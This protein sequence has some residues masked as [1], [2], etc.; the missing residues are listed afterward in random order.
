VGVLRSFLDGF[1][2]I[3]NSDR[4]KWPIEGGFLVEIEEPYRRGRGLVFKGFRGQYQLGWGRPGSNPLPPLDVTPEEI[5]SW[6]PPPELPPYPLSPPAD[7]LLYELLYP[8]SKMVYH[9]SSDFGDPCWLPFLDTSGCTEDARRFLL[10]PAEAGTLD[11]EGS[12]GE[13]P[14]PDEGP[15]QEARRTPGHFGA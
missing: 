12:A 13:P 11:S 1:Y 7:G 8:G 5:G 15:A 6:N 14:A 9:L 2:L 3:P 10:P 4:P